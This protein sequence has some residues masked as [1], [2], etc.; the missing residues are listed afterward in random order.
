MHSGALRSRSG[1]A[2]EASLSLSTHGP[3]LNLPY[4]SCLEAHLALAHLEGVP[5]SW[6]AADFEM[7]NCPFPVVVSSMTDPSFSVV[8]TSK[9]NSSS[10]CLA[11]CF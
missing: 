5:P 9:R 2:A 10:H 4:S 6:Q 3:L 8:P 1:S 11:V 7:S